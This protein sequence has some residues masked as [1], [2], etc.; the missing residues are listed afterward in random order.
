M[1]RV[2]PVKT[3]VLCEGNHT[4]FSEKM[5]MLSNS[6]PVSIKAKT[7]NDDTM[8]LNIDFMTKDMNNALT[9]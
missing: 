7:P 9:V 3:P 6:V 4:M 5:L 2:L 1:L 8:A